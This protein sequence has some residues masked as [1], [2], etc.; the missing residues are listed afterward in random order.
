MKSYSLLCM[1]AGIL[2]LSIIL[3]A[4]A[5]TEF[6]LFSEYIS[7]IGVGPLSLIFNSSLVLS[8]ILIIPFVLKARMHYKYSTILF[9]AAAVSLAAVG[10]FP[11]TSEFHSIVAGTFFV[12]AF[13]SVLFA[14]LGMK[15][16]K[17]NISIAVAILCA[18][19]LIFFNPFVETLQ[20]FSVGIWVAAVGFLNRKKTT[21]PVRKDVP[22]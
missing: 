22:L 21:S 5:S 1:I 20:V 8:A 11:L 16:R 13:A 4:S 3:I 18:T 19:G 14:G 6:S 9:L 15:G 12:L 7:D 10:I 17:K 2:P